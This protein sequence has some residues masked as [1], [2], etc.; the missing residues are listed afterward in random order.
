MSKEKLSWEALAAKRGIKPKRN[1]A[2]MDSVEDL[3]ASIFATQTSTT[4]IDD[5]EQAP[6]WKQ[7]KAAMIRAEKG[8]FYP[9]IIDFSPNG[10]SEHMK[11]Q[12]SEY[13]N[14]PIWYT[15]TPSWELPAD[16]DE[17]MQGFAAHQIADADVDAE[18]WEAYV[19]LALPMGAGLSALLVAEV[20]KQYGVF[21]TVAHFYQPDPINEPGLW[22][23]AGCED[24]NN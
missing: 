1:P 7:E 22:E 2:K 8:M 4:V 20:K 14:R 9:D 15:A 18:G 17:T 3:E 12:I 19:V 13:L 11:S 5:V 16:G 6:E 10:L 24:L 23:L 21:P